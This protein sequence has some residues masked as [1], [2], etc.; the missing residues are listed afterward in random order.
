[1]SKKRCKKKDYSAPE[2]PKYCCK[3]CGRLANK[4]DKVCEPKKVK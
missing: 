3:N 1:M 2:N 4:E